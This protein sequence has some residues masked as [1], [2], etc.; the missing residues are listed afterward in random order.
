MKRMYLSVQA[1]LMVLM[2]G[3]ATQPIFAAEPLPSGS[4]AVTPAAANSNQYGL[5]GWLDRRSQYGQGAFPEPFLADDSDL[6]QREFRL[7]W[8]HQEGR[9]QVGDEVTTEIEKGFGLLTLEIELHYER[10]SSRSFN[11]VTG[12][13]DTDVEEGIGNVDLGARYPIYQYVSPD[14]FI[15]TT[16]GVAF[17]VGIPTNSRVSKNTEIV[18]KVFG[19]FRIGDHI[20]IQSIFGY[21]MLKGSK[22]DGGLETVEYGFD[23]GY[24]IP[25]SELPLPGIEQFIPMFELAGE[26]QMNGE[27]AGHNSLTGN[28][29]FRLNLKAIN[30]V[31]P[32]LG[33][34]YVFPLDHDARDDFRWGII[35]SLVFEF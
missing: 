35:T 10:G 28:V 21:S 24:T 22:P 6:E 34:G 31:Q 8:I 9:G 19:D 5:F 20:T 33:I 11:A 7:D 23:F 15:D 25:H 12:H 2:A 4:T 27:D 18:P 17:E 13:T 14:Q 16:F 3:L 1:G 26:H 30:G 29:A 32:R